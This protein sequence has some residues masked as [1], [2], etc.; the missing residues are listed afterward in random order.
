[1]YYYLTLSERWLTATPTSTLTEQGITAIP[2]EYSLPGYS[3]AKVN[4][5]NS[6]SLGTVGSSSKVSSSPVT[7][8]FSSVAKA[9]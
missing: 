3:I 2:T 7:F 8:L 4:Q 9:S 1:M 6:P 5:K